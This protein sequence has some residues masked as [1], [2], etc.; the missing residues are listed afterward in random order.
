MTSQIDIRDAPLPQG[1]QALLVD[2]PRE[3]WAD[4]PNFRLA[5]KNWLGAHRA[6]RHLAKLTC[7]KTE[8]YL[9]GSFEPNEYAADLSYYGDALVRNLHGHHSWEDQ[10]Y[11]P[12]LARAE[13]RFKAG[14][15]TLEQDHQVLNTLLNG[16]TLKSNRVIK[17]I[18][19]DETQ[20]QEEA[21]GLLSICEKLN[22]LLTLHLS[23]EEDFAVPIILHHKLRG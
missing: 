10:S 18:Q 9:E 21:I 16:F 12:E 5:T 14:L 8:S 15:E 13:P 22:A 4:Y 2:Y 1:M 17:L 3:A 7:R 19:L 11:F 23:D 20:A 6:F